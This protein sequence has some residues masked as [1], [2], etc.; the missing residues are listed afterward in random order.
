MLP[1]FLVHVYAPVSVVARAI[2][3]VTFPFYL[4]ATLPSALIIVP[5]LIPVTAPFL[6]ERI[7]VTSLTVTF[8]CFSGFVFV[9]F[10]LPTTPSYWPC[11]ACATSSCCS[12]T[13]SGP[14]DATQG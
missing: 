12:C 2:I 6:A 9:T 13:S 10:P 7:T 4:A 3:F 8:L 14:C 5:L 11:P 1:L